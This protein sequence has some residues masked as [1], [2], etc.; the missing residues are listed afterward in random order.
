MCTKLPGCL[1][2]LDKPFQSMHSRQ[3]QNNLL[4]KE[5]RRSARVDKTLLLLLAAPWSAVDIGEQVVE[6]LG[7]ILAFDAIQFVFAGTPPADAAG[8]TERFRA[9]RAV[10]ALQSEIRA[11]QREG[12]GGT[13]TA[14]C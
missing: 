8:I 13:A 3:E 6:E 9:V 4:E 11:R 5:R 1:F 2:W 12:E 10:P 7:L 14:G